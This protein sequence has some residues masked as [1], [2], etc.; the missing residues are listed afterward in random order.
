VQSL[1]VDLITNILGNIFTWLFFGVVT[2]S[3]VR[4][5]S[6]TEFETFF[7]LTHRKRVV[8]YLSNLWDPAQTTVN[9]PWGSVVAGQEFQA[10]QTISRLFGVSPFSLPE[11]VRGF[12]DAFWISRRVGVDLTVSPMNGGIDA[13]NNL[14]VVGSTLK[15]K[16]RR[17]YAR[18]NVLHAIIDGEPIDIADDKINIHTNPLMPQFRVICGTRTG[19]TTHRTGEYELA[20]VEKVRDHDRVIFFCL[21]TTGCGS[22]AAVEYLARNWETLWKEK[23]D[24]RF[25]RCL[26]FLRQNIHGQ[27]PSWEPADYE[28]IP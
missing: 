24:R 5:R 22:R 10:S 19:D 3:I 28:D 1:L 13:N 27:S 6:Q 20:I 11:L 14:I 7:G 8:V 4:H 17:I 2:L 21:G 9:E 18:K 25:T 26:W 23:K 15:N 12:V 16:V